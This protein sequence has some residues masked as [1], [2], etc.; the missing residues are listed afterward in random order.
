MAKTAHKPQ[1]APKEVPTLTREQMIAE[2]RNLRAG[3]LFVGNMAYVDAL[4]AAYDEAWQELYRMRTDAEAAEIL[5][6]LDGVAE[7]DAGAGA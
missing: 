4:L 5:E 6:R 1:M 2:V 3:N 7:L